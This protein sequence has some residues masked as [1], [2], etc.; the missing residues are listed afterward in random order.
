[1]FLYGAN[2][3][4]T[5]PALDLYRPVAGADSLPLPYADVGIRAGFP[6]PAQDYLA[7]TIDL[8][9]LLIDHPSSTFFGRVRGD[10]MI[11]ADICDG[12]LL[13]ID[14]SLQ[15]QQG[16]LAV[17]CVDGD[18]TLKFIEIKADG[19]RLM[20]ANRKYK[21]IRITRE[22]EFV[23]WGVVTHTIKRHRSRRR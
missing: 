15:P 17:C 23:V 1:M 3:K 22:N 14:K 7:E 6:S 12:D 18:F 4:C 21:P 13:I 2:M 19:I 10:S 9:D 16:D 20:P 5:G 11:D 8:N